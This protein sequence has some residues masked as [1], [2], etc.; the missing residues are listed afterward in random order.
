M[1]AF[2]IILGPVDNLSPFPFKDGGPFGGW[3]FFN[4]FGGRGGGGANG[5]DGC[6]SLGEG[7]AHLA[8]VHQIMIFKNV[9]PIHFYNKLL[10]MGQEGL[11]QVMKELDRPK[12]F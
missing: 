8:L 3:T 11:G 1:E 2:S 6:F 10:Q 9:E 7:G 12:N 5:R 4:G